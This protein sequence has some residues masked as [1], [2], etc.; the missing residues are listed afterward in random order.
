M[1]SLQ[2][3]EF[4]EKEFCFL[5]DTISASLPPVRPPKI[6]EIV[7]RAAGRCIVLLAG[8]LSPRKGV[9]IF[10]DLVETAQT[11]KYFFV[12]AGQIYHQTFSPTLLKRFYGLANDN[13]ERLIIHEG[14]IKDDLPFNAYINASDILYA[15]YRDWPHSSGMLAKAAVMKV[16]VLVSEK[17]L[18]GERVL[19]YQI[20]EAIP[21]HNL[22]ECLLALDRLQHNKIPSQNYTDYLTDFSKDIFD[23]NL[24]EFVANAHL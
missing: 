13:P 17:Y 24:K 16:P 1:V 15:Y 8:S 10:C 23:I 2:E 3:R 20:G 18:L 9:E 11:D 6:E 5:P 12:A 19:R 22:E 4:P 21:E 7:S 14:Y